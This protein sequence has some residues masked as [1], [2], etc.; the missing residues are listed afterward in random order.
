MTE[1]V[2]D[3]I[4]TYYLIDKSGNIYSLKTKR[5]L[6]P[7]KNKNGYCIV[8]IHY[9]GKS[10]YCQVHRLVAKTFIPNPLNLE[11]VNH[12]DGNKSNNCVSNLEWMSRKDNV[13]HAWR[14]GLAKPRY[15]IDN[16]ANK[17]SPEQIHK[18][19]KLLEEQKLK[20]IEISKICNVNITVIYDIRIRD[21][22][23]DISSQYN[24]PKTKIGF[25]EYRSK[26]INL[27]NNGLDN[28][29]IIN[30][31]GLPDTNL[32]RRHIEYVRSRYKYSPND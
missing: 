1:L 16:P 26:I 30:E 18:V 32:L 7:F 4:K 6:K 9:N 11:T 20:Y 12:I 31:L 28:K 15:G 2:I 22:W 25:V 23:H 8:D 17:Y 14:T 3:N 10:K 13:N 29:S 19:C 24:I 21:K 27:I 5:I